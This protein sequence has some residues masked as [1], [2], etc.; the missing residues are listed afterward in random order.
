MTKK[1]A[2]VILASIS[3]LAAASVILLQKKDKR[4][5]GSDKLPVVLHSL[6]LP[7]GW[8]YEVMVDDKLFIHQDCIP[9]ISS[10]KRFASEAEALRI[11]NRVVDKIKH[12]HKPTITTGE[13][14]D[15]H[16]HY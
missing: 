10:Y 14:A 12:G 2:V 13:L 5:T 16:I 1:Y 11:G 7:D 3:M 4:A 8:G 9:A 6:K 15:A